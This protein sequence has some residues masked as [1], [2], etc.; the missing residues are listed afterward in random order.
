MNNYHK[1]ILNKFLEYEHL[2][3]IRDRGLLVLI[4]CVPK[5]LNYIEEHDLRLQEVRLKEAIAY[6]GYLI[7]TGRI[8]GGKY[9]ANTIRTMIVSAKRFY[10]YLKRIN[11]IITNPFTELR[12]VRLEERIPRNIL[13][14]KQMNDLLMRLSHFE[15]IPTLKKQIVYYRIHVV[16]EVL[17]AS[18]LRI[19]EAAALKVEDIDF[20]RGII[21]VKRGKGG[22]DRTAYL[23]EYA[24]ELLR[25]YVEN[26]R[27]YVFI[28][29][30]HKNGSLFGVD[31][32]RLKELVNDE[33]RLF[34]K[35]HKIPRQTSHNFRHA[36]GT[37]LLRAGCDI[38]Y[39]QE[40]LGH[41]CIR[42]TEFYTKV[43]KD[44][45]K[46]V[47]DQYHPRTFKKDKGKK[48]DKT[49]S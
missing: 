5:L 20:I 35:K 9:S 43:T 4:R 24:K 19:S 44:D 33:L 40:I 18:G 25:V 42:S 28:E 38:R 47:L 29:Y 49:K 27:Y 11:I 45:L 17:Y 3:G 37:H 13:K 36:L 31:W 26:A 10:D 46:R 41:K 1:T 21:R 2:R 39:V 34:C 8:D 22:I 16:C 48:D 15:K 7:D 30:N 12:R 14:E 32:E 6:Q 23:N